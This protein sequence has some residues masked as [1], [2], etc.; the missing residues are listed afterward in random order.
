M[1]QTERLRAWYNGD[2]EDEDLTA[3]DMRELERRV[4]KAVSRKILVRDDVHTFPE[5]RTVQ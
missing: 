3:A 4:F 2:L 1:T 5:H